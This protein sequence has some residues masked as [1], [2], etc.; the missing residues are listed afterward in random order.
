MPWRIAVAL[1]QGLLLWWLYYAARQAYWPSEHPG[2]LV[3]LAT[4]AAVTPVARYLVEELAPLG[5]QLQLLAA[6]ALVLFGLGWHEGAWAGGESHDEHFGFV[7]ALGVL[8][9]HVLP[10][11]QLR[12]ASGGWRP[13]YPPLFD[14]AWRNALLVGLGA[15]F[16]GVFWML[17]WLWAKL[18]DL[19][20]IDF[21]AN[22]FG[23]EAFAIPATTVA[24]GVGV[25]LAGS[26]DRLQS[27]LRQQLL[28]LFKWLLPL[29]ALILVLFTAALLVKSPELLLEERRAISAVWLL[30]L[31]AVSIAL[32]NAAYQDG[33]LEAPYP[34]WLGTAIRLVVP[35]LLPVAVLAAIAL[36]IRAEHYGL[37]AP[38]VWGFAV[39]A[40]ALAYAAGYAWAALRKSP[41]L[42][43]I[44]AVNV[45]VAIGTI[46]LLTLMLSPALSPQR[47]AAA[48]QYARA[49][50][51]REESS[52]VHLRFESGRYGR[53]RLA[54][55]AKLT[56]HPEAAQIRELAGRELEKRSR[57]RDPMP[58]ARL[59]ADAFEVFPAGNALDPELLA[60]IRG[61]RDVEFLGRCIRY[62]PCPVLL[63]D[64]T[65]DGAPEA[66]IFEDHVV[67]AAT[68]EAGAWRL[69]PRQP[70]ET[71][72]RAK[73]EVRD[74]LR[75]GRYRTRELPWEVLEI[76]GSRFVFDQP[77]AAE[78]ATDAAPARDSP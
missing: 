73:S 66:L 50:D 44:G 39:A 8:M 69:L 61:S 38:R 54:R 29:A 19:L 47:L 27:V 62:D 76:D 18:F 65:R 6:L 49:L 20:G 77:D 55:L 32:L 41:W 74:A 59:G 17:L 67:V 57:W 14:F 53:N 31:V 56:D 58:V 23:E 28:T 5:R 12:L 71:A 11:V 15:A 37:T 36:A 13:S 72:H 30:W 35:L 3:G 24:F 60:A 21:F 26:V 10:F 34:R 2:L 51:E 43:R 4:A 52:F 70:F 22:L 46:T 78:T 9:F 25:Q 48:S 7:V 1:G 68:R 16:T 75:Q 45:G 42:A 33:R 63:L 64:L 40:V